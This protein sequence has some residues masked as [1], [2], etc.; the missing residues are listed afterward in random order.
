MAK[1]ITLQYLSPVTRVMSAP[2]HL[3]SSHHCFLQMPELKRVGRNRSY[4]ANPAPG[5]IDR[6][7]HF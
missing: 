1:F 2:Y 7:H 3:A 4:F 5:A 6:F